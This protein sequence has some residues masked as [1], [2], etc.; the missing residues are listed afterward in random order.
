MIRKLLI[1]SGKGGTGKTTT[2]AAFLRFARARA[3]ADCDVDAPNLHLVAGLDGPPERSDY[4]GGEKA[5]IDAGRCTGC[6]ACVRACRFHALRLEDGVCRVNEYACEG[7]G[8]CA[9]VCPEGAASLQADLAGTL[10]LYRGDRVFSTA[11]LR[12]GRGTSGKLVSAVKLALLQ[13]APDTPLAILDGSP[14]IGCPVISS[15]SGADLVLL[16]TEPSLSGRNDLERILK[17]AAGLGAPVAVCVNKYDLCPQQADAVEALCR[18][19]GVPF[20]GRIPYDP[21]A[22]RAANTGKS[23]AD[24]GGPACDA[25]RQ[26]YQRVMDLMGLSQSLSEP[27]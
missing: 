10:E 19:Q 26:I 21:A 22:A 13:N 7:C 4:T 17:T 25:L 6:G 14:G 12:M 9:H 23:L 11:S 18:E 15:I 3:F 8:V 2:A 1:L 24:L 5:Q 20:V 27:S 16:V